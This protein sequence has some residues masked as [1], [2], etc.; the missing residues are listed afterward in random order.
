MYPTHNRQRAERRS[1]LSAEFERYCVLSRET[2]HRNFAL[3]LKRRNECIIELII[4]FSKWESNPTT[5]ALQPHLCAP[6]QRPQ[7]N[8]IHFSI[9]STHIQIYNILSIYISKHIVSRRV[10]T[11]QEFPL[12]IFLIYSSRYTASSLLMAKCN[13][14]RL[15]ER[16]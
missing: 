12:V 5:V 13:C 1:T 16:Q 2:Q 10:L 8:Y 15:D 7:S 9:Y 4:Y 6:T 3:M 11:S 14:Y